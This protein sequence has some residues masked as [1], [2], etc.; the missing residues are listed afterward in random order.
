MKK[1]TTALWRIL[2]GPAVQVS[3]LHGVIAGRRMCNSF[4]MLQSHVHM[5]QFHLKRFN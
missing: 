5:K 1:S 2:W 4:K 3:Q